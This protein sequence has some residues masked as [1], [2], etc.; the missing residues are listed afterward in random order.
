MKNEVCRIINRIITLYK[1]EEIVIEKLNFI[2]PNLSKRLN[3]L[4][5]K[6]GKREIEN[7]FS[8]TSEELNTKITYVNPAYT[9]QECS[10]CGYIDK[11]NRKSQEE[12]KCKLCNLSLNADI[13]GAKN[14]FKR[15][16]LKEVSV[17]RSK[18]QVL[19]I[20][21]GNFLRDM[22]RH[23]RLYSKA[24]VLTSENPYFRSEMKGFT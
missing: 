13:N 5:S 23:R 1:P 20:L 3:R 11:G 6:F 9:S 4:I 17:Y 21:T 7:K 2:S 22:E 8:S 19:R 10:R 24:L 18:K 16:S 14:I 15:S 12:F